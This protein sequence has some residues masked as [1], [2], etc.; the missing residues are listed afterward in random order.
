MSKHTRPGDTISF[1]DL[2]EKM[3]KL[4]KPKEGEPRYPKN[5]HEAP[6][7]TEFPLYYKAEDGTPTGEIK[8]YMYVLTCPIC[9][10]EIKRSDTFCRECGN[11]V[12][13]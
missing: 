3:M 9:G 1:R 7:Y 12:A 4:M 8:A 13:K 6:V 2:L 10:H 5:Q 11:K